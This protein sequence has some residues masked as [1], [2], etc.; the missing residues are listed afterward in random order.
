MI[1]LLSVKRTTGEGAYKDFG[2]LPRA[3]MVLGSMRFYSIL[4]I[5][6]SL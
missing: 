1:G 4:W 5:I 2:S 6:L 3:K